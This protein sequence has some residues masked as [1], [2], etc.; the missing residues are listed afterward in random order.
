[1]AITKIHAVKTT[2][3][4][5][6]NYICNPEKTDDDC[7]KSYW[8]IRHISDE[9]TSYMG[10]EQEQAQEKDHDKKPSL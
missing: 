6:V 2:I 10:M 7:K 9:L 3:S 4:R 5:S 8:N 1:M